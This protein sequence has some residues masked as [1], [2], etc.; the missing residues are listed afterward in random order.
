M[1]EA[2]TFFDRQQTTLLMTDSHGE[3]F[4]RNKMVLLA[5]ARGKMA[6][7]N[8]AAAVKVE[9]DV[10]TIAGLAGHLSAQGTSA[11]VRGGAGGQR[12]VSA[13]A[14]PARARTTGA[15]GGGS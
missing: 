7:T 8:A 6:V 3:Y 14:Q 2:M 11:S 4:L 1:R 5:E 10:P 9:G 13:P 12:A 15:G